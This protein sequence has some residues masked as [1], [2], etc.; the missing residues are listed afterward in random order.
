[1]V[2]N[3]HPIKSHLVVEYYKLL[4]NNIKKKK[5]KDNVDKV[6]RISKQSLLPFCSDAP[7]FDGFRIHNVA[8]VAQEVFV[9]LLFSGKLF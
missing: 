1:M 8:S 4:V 6:E 3:F 9:L 5:K 2:K 7:R